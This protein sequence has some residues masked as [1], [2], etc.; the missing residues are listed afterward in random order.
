MS[1]YSLS[2][3]IALALLA[4]TLL[5]G[6]KQ[7]VPGCASEEATGL[8]KELLNKQTN[9]WSAFWSMALEV[10][11]NADE[12]TEIAYELESIRTQNTN[13]QTGAHACAAEL[14]IVYGG[15]KILTHPINY[16]VEITD[17]GSSLYVTLKE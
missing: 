7:K 13:S 5:L 8:L 11:H 16:S 1:H 15:E 4:A 12:E 14:H 6:C 17:D 9:Q 2:T 10:E 3:R